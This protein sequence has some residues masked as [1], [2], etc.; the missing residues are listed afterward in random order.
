MVDMYRRVRGLTL[1]L[2]LGRYDGRIIRIAGTSVTVINRGG[3]SAVMVDY[4]AQA[5]WRYIAN[6]ERFIK[7]CLNKY[8]K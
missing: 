3:V 2:T 5:V 8:V 4:L 6:E 7:G 1:T